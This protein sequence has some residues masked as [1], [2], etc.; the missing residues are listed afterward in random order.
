MRVSARE[1]TAGAGCEWERC[2]V[3]VPREGAGQ[4][5]DGGEPVGGL[6]WL[7]MVTGLG[8]AHGN[9]SE[10]RGGEGGRGTKG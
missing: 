4:V 2:R 7:L 8:P 5:G 6:G 10:G 1:Q 9:E 3:R